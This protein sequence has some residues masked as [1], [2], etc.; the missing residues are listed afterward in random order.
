[1]GFEYINRPLR[2]IIKP[3]G[4]PVGTVVN[5]RQNMSLTSSMGFWSWLQTDIVFPIML[6]Q[7]V[8]TGF[9]DFD[10]SV[11][12]VAF[13]DMKFVPRVNFLKTGTFSLGFALPVTLPSGNAASFVGEEGATVTPTVLIGFRTD[14]FQAD[15]NVGYIAR[16]DQS[17]RFSSQH[18]TADDE[19]VYGLGLRIPIVGK[20]GF[21]NRLDL[22]GD[23]WGSMS[24]YEQDKEELPLE[25]M[26]GLQAHL[27]HGV[28]M[29]FGAGGG[30]TKG[31]GTS[32]YRVMWGFG[33]EFNHPKPK[34]CKSKVFVVNI[35]IPVPIAVPVV[36][37]IVVKKHKIILPP[38]FFAF[39]KGEIL[40]QSYPTLQEVA[41]ILK[42]NKEI[43]EVVLGGHA[44]SRGSDEYNFDLGWHRA[45]RVW[46]AL[47]DMG[48]HP[49][50]M[51]PV[52][53][54]EWVNKIK[55]AKTEKSHA[56]NRRV[57]F[58]ILEVK[59]P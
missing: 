36:K 14:Y 56:R 46:N 54:G 24:V 50:R 57:E 23:L 55:N 41:D 10:E 20:Y 7:G 8:T 58:N 35:P 33:W 19:L 43:V 44:D 5:W 29:T 53:F 45:K 30:L 27:A 42:K 3:G 9:L 4:S 40:T 47:I 59:V 1:L 13:Y 48:I 25:V 22:Q 31:L 37:K 16:T 39:D 49:N 2:V 51:I 11:E 21:L 26:G 12:D 52:S 18:I 6:G 34:P 38:V 15:L 28:T 32:Q 17:Y